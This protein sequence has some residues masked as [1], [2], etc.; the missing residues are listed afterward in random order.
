MI[1]VKNFP[2][3]YLPT[4][5]GNIQ[6]DGYSASYVCISVSKFYLATVLRIM[7]NVQ[8]YFNKEKSLK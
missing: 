4:F 1:Y 2:C 7:I 8:V 6:Y 5:K 3:T